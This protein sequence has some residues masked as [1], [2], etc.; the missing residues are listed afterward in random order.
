[1]EVIV[2]HQNA[3][4]DS[5]GSL[6]LARKL[7]P[8]AALVLPDRM[9]GEVYDMAGDMLRDHFLLRKP[10]EI[11]L[12]K[13]TRLILVDTK[14][15]SRIG[16]LAEVAARSD[17]E[18]HIYDHHPKAEEDLSGDLE[19]IR[20]VGA[21]VTILVELLQ[22]E[23]FTL[24]PEE[25][26]WA[27]LGLYQDTGRLTF[28]TT[29]DDLRA[30]AWLLEQK[31]DLEIVEEALNRGP[32]AE[33]IIV[34]HDMLRAVTHFN[35]HGQ[36]VLLTEVSI[37]HHIAELNK[38]VD[39]LRRMRGAM[40]VLA[41]VVEDKKIH[42]IG[43]SAP[44]ALDVAKVAEA[45][46]GGGHPE[47]AAA[48]IK[49]CTLVEVRERLVQLLPMFAERQP[50][51]R[52]LMCSP[53]IML[54]YDKTVGDAEQ[55]FVEKQV[56]AV[57][58]TDDKNDLHGIITHTDIKR[59]LHHGLDNTE[60]AALIDAQ[61]I[62]CS[63]DTSLTDLYRIA[64]N[65]RQRI[66]PVM[67]NDQVI[68]VVSRTDIFRTLTE[69][70]LPDVDDD[71]RP[72]VTEG[73]ETL[74]NTAG[75]L[76]QRLPDDL[77]KL[78]E[79]LG[80]VTAEKKMTAYLVGGFVRDL[81]LQR[82][83]LD[84]DIVIEGDAL[85]PTQQVGEEFGATVSVHKDFQTASLFWGEYNLDIATSRSEFY[86]EPAAL[87]VVEPTSIRRDLVRRDFTINT[88]L[89]RLDPDHFGELVDLYSGLNDLKR[90][91]LRVLH[92]LS[93][94]EDPTRIF[95]GC[96]LAV[97][98]EME[99][100]F[101]TLRLMQTAANKGYIA[102]LAGSRI[103]K[104]L[105]L[106]FHEEKAYEILAWMLTTD[107]LKTVHPDWREND[108]LDN[109]LKNTSEMLSW[110]DKLY[111]DRKL[112][113]ELLWLTALTAYLSEKERK[114]LAKR[115][116]LPAHLA[117]KAPVYVTRS[118]ELV[119]RLLRADNAKTSE[120]AA[121]LRAQPTEILL[122][123]SILSDKDEVRKAISQ[124][125]TDWD[126]VKPLIN[127]ND[128]QTMGLEPGPQFSKILDAVRD[129]RLDGEVKNRDGELALARRL[130]ELKNTGEH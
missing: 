12:S 21:T 110:F 66:V 105:A 90:R 94:I 118:H 130:A 75:Q 114:K 28:N 121:A 53:P 122:L 83:N 93:F 113:V 22:Q 7:Y 97:R 64:I 35:L 120:L 23:H 54:H 10:G 38:C 80:A 116:E 45:F 96:R 41:L 46:G 128:L 85:L 87:P 49:D 99:I 6:I 76:R 119:G 16:S 92:A 88:M 20:D 79:R 36:D 42:L 15:P 8:K 57:V 67:E 112:D 109:C 108:K 34:L 104:E 59:A 111:L 19:V 129:A 5:I 82:D 91:Q 73:F 60:L 52:E 98:L 47:A 107:L 4:W 58:I 125:F 14:K 1:M 95:R 43:R 62:P 13:I 72:G 11:D 37:P 61:P 86:R 44:G 103:W 48:L 123:A 2:C 56:H 74:R 126:K 81:I 84:I 27:L 127:G 89:I 69:R 30:G 18:V 100:G 70:Q 3:D 65:R 24:S 78:I 31:A 106:I 101:Y 26:T 33:Q 102:Q 50:T 25:A 32:S 9:K 63:P 55:L 40:A 71:G 68:G 77:L 39:E 124:F 51:A 29:P 117:D 115:L 17:V